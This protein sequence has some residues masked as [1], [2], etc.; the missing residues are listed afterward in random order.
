MPRP[1]VCSIAPCSA[2]LLLAAACA[3]THGEGG[4]LG[5]RY[6]AVHNTLAAMGLAQVGPI[7]EGTLAEGREAR[8]SLDLPGGCATIVAVGGDGVR[9]VDATLLDPHGAPVAHDTTSE[10]QAVLRAC[11]DQADAYTLVVKAAAGSGSWV[12]ATWAGG[13]GGGG[14]A[15][16]SPT[17]LAGAQAAG[18]CD[19]PIPLTVGTVTGSTRRGQRDNASPRCQSD[20]RELVYELDLTQRQRV[21]FDVEA[22]FDSVLYLR[23]DECGEQS[24]EVDCNDDAGGERTRSRLERVL[25]PGKY[26]VFVDGYQNEAGSFKLTVSASDVVSLQDVCRRAQPLAQGAVVTGATRRLAD[27]VH[28]T[29]GDGAEG[30]DE[31]WRVDLPSRVRARF[32][33]HSDDLA[34]VV[35]VRR[36]CA[37]EQSE[38]DC[39]DT[40]TGVGDA[41]VVGLFDPGQYTVFA[42]G[43]RSDQTGTYT[44][45]LDVAP[46]SGSGT[47]GDACDD[48]Q[49]LAGATG[50]L[51]GDT[52]AAHDDVSGSCGGAG[53]ADVVYRMDVT[54][55]SRVVLSI[56]SEESEHLL[57]VWKRCGD[58]GAEVACARSVDEV[59]APGTYFVAVDG[60]A[61]EKMGRFALSWAQHDLTAQTAACAAVPGLAAGGTAS[62]TT[63]GAADKF[64]AS[65]VTSDGGP[66]GPDRVYKITLASHATV[67]LAVTAATFDASLTLRKSCVDGPGGASAAELECAGESDGAHHTSIDRDLESGTYYVVV[68]GQSATDQGPYTLEYKLIR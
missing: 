68:D 33:E 44:L 5:P 8:V 66:S 13:I 62:G 54:R 6:V 49:P 35:H 3:T 46:P 51:A 53:A 39:A 2:A 12:V 7:H 27:N 50:T 31:P 4:E 18:T 43:R 64:I 14:S 21:T 63:I 25:E 37:D 36:S 10:P 47:T 1:L 15:G 16:P 22:Q 24:A 45:Q 9:D 38:V 17:G 20:G 26:F 34:P 40:T 48:A 19:S 29:C 23:K 57:V 11:V 58:K 56:D 28:A 41:A 65:C 52:F 32:T 30:A 60:T 67:H 42:D 55:R 61:P 59:L